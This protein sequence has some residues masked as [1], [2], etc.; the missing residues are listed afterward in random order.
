[1][2]LM[3][4]PGAKNRTHD[5]SLDSSGDPDW[6]TL[7][8]NVDMGALWARI[9]A[10]NDGFAALLRERYGDHPELLIWRSAMTVVDPLAQGN[11]LGKAM[12]KFIL[13]RVKRSGMPWGHGCLGHTVRS[14]FHPLST[15]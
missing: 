10:V 3:F 11:G 15:S 13:D 4:Q 1:M 2:R 9:A 5:R 8:Q 14:S 12:N 6:A 7:E